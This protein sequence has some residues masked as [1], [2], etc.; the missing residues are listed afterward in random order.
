MRIA[1]NQQ[2]IE[3]FRK[4]PGCIKQA[5]SCRECMNTGKTH[6]ATIVAQ[7]HIHQQ[8]EWKCACDMRLA[9]RHR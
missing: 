8:R 5:S 3:I 6:W 9:N 2:Q 7:M 1:E 4:H